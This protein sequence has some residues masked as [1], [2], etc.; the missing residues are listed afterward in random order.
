[1][2][3]KTFSYRSIKIFVLISTLLIIFSS[4]DIVDAITDVFKGDNDDNIS[5]QQ[6]QALTN[7]LNIQDDASDIMDNLFSSGFD[8]LTVIDSLYIF[9]LNDTSIQNVWADSEGVAVEYNNGISG[10][11]FVGIYHNPIVDSS[12]P[13]TFII[14][15]SDRE[16]KKSINT[17]D[18]Y[19]PGIKKSVFFD[20][21]YEEFKE[22]DDP[23]ISTANNSFVRVG[24]APF[25]KYLDHDATLNVL[26]TLSDYGIIHLTGHGWYRKK[27]FGIGSG[28]AK[29][30]YLLTEEVADINKINGDI[31]QDMLD[32]NIIV[33][34]HKNENRY[35]V[36]PKYISDRNNFHGNEVFVYNGFCS[37]GRSA[38]QKEIWTNAGAS[39]F[40]GIK[41]SV[42]A[43][44][45]TEWAKD[46]YEKMCDTDLDQPMK[47]WDCTI[48]IIKGYHGY[49]NAWY[50][51]DQM[52]YHNRYVHLRMKG[53]GEY[54]FW[55]KELE[56]FGV[57]IE[58]SVHNVTGRRRESYSHNGDWYD[59]LHR[60]IYF[61][62]LDSGTHNSS[63]NVVNNVY[64]GTIDNY[65]PNTRSVSG[66]IQITF[67]DDKQL[68]LHIDRTET[69]NDSWDG[70]AWS[71]LTTTAWESNWT[72][73]IIIDYDGVPG[74]WDITDT[75]QPYS[76]YPAT[77]IKKIVKYE[78]YDRTDTDIKVS[79]K[80]HG[81][82]GDKDWDVEYLSH[83]Y[84]GN[85]NYIEVR[86][87][88][89]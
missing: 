74:G 60:G 29:I 12:P 65:Y 41:Y 76:L 59:L 26:S 80:T 87:Y 23:V 9:F 27:V 82:I 37:G 75:Y 44:W 6:E 40:V 10:G 47:L 81:I 16:L 83:S 48:E 32:K 51:D 17:S 64:T 50:V 71:S 3:T 39:A 62:D 58:V 43:S 57:L 33:I 55:E 11:I 77:N 86:V 8:T 79:Y 63:G 34:T 35:W 14:E 85:P 22:Y 88:Y 7:V 61:Y 78:V 45:E 46:M 56:M 25:K 31:W 5:N 84:E 72:E 24:I 15:L 53:D 67:T 69:G 54:T 2:I 89:K 73:Q 68:N 18:S 38:W 52:R 13:D 30:T 28:T 19:S 49:Y 4:C 36:S 20:G 66:N 21:G 42:E 70:G 1:M